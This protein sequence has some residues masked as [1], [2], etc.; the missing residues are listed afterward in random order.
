MSKSELKRL[1]VQAGVYI[2]QPELVC[3][4]CGMLFGRKPIPFPLI[5]AAWRDGTCGVCGDVTY[6][7]GPEDFGYLVEGWK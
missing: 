4:D 1:N 2:D 7:T 6:V 5:I 3:V